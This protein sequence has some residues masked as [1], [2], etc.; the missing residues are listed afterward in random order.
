MPKVVMILMW[1]EEENRLYKISEQSKNKVGE[2][3]ATNKS[4]HFHEK[5]YSFHVSNRI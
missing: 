3:K 4:D 5:A 1:G 2:E